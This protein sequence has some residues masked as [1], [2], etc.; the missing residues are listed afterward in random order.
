MFEPRNQYSR[1]LVPLDLQLFH[2]ASSLLSSTLGCMLDPMKEMADIL[3]VDGHNFGRK[4]KST[5]L[6]RG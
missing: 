6:A 2:S 4:S 1:T 5:M 3:L